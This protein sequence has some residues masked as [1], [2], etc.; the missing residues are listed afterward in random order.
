MITATLISKTLNGASLQV[1]KRSPL[2]SD[3]EHGGTQADTVQEV[4]DFYTQI[5]RQWEDLTS[6]L[7]IEISDFLVVSHFLQGHTF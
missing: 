4:A 2:S 6:H 7:E 5:Q 1:Q 3:R